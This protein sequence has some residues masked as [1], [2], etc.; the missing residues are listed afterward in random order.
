MET[1]KTKL[2]TVLGNLLYLTL[3][4]NEECDEA[5]SKDPVECKQFY[6]KLL[7]LSLILT[8][9]LPIESCVKLYI[10]LYIYIKYCEIL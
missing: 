4:E 6:V 9:Y 3:L 2:G 1:L 10:C 7:Y 8:L 5:T